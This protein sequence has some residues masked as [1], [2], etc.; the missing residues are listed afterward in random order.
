L[1][2]TDIARAYRAQY[3]R[4][5]SYAAALASPSVVECDIATSDNYYSGLILSS[6][7]DLYTKAITNGTG[8][9]CAA[10]QEDNGSLE[11]LMRGAKAG[12]VDFSRV[13]R[14]SGSLVW[15]SF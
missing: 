3:A 5:A 8:K 7:F 14:K 13:I 11:A 15:P 10:A 4:N 9:Y 12:K 6:N 1:A 2:D